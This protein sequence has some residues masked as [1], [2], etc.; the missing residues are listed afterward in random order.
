MKEKNI[1]EKKKKQKVSKILSNNIFMLKLI[2][3][4]AP[5]YI[6]ISVFLTIAWPFLNFLQSSYMLRYV[7]NG[8]QEGKTFGALAPFVIIILKKLLHR[9]YWCLHLQKC[10]PMLCQ[11]VQPQGPEVLRFRLQLQRQN[12]PE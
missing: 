1:K 9:I 7:I 5:L 3:K 8:V 4:A 11:Q 6:P 10:R 12:L 2:W